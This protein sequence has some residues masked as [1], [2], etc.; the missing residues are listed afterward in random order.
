[1]VMI[2]DNRAGTAIEPEGEAS[3]YDRQAVMSVDMADNAETERV[4][5]DA[6]RPEQ[7]L[8]FQPSHTR[9]NTH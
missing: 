9:R 2:D 3:V 6:L 1:M 4:E 7:E 8:A 5:V